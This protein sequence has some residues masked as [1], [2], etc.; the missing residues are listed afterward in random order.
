MSMHRLP[1]NLD[2]LPVSIIELAE[3]LSIRVAIAFIQHF[4]GMEVKFPVKPRSDHPVIMALGE[5]D[6]L[7]ICQYLGGEQFYVPHV[8]RRRSARAD[9]LRMDAN[10]MDRNQ[11]ARALGLSVR[12]VRRMANRHDDDRQHPLFPE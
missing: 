7:A 4:G 10:G 12:H 6:G 3:T 11:I 2:A 9:I 5:A 1:S 8:R